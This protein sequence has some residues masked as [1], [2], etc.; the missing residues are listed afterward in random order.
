M[1]LLQA[2]SIL[3]LV[4]GIG[5]HIEDYIKTTDVGASES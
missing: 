3:I 5:L 4:K 1:E 2:S